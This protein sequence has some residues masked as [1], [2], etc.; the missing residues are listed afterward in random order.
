[1]LALRGVP[2][3][4]SKGLL[5]QFRA[6]LVDTGLS[7]ATVVNY[8]AD[9]RAFWRWSEKARDAEVS[10]FGLEPPD[11]EEY[12]AFLRDGR[13]QA[14]ATVNRRLQA[15]RKFFKFAMEQGW[16]RTNPAEDVALLSEAVSQRSRFLTPSDVARLLDAVRNGRRRWADRDWAIMQAFLGAGLKLSELTQLLLKDVHLD[17]EQPCLDVRNTAGEPD[18]CVPLDSQVCDAMR[19]YAAVRRSVR[20]VQHFFVNRDGRPLSTR[21]VQRLLRH[22]ARTAQLSDLT[23]QALRYLYARKAFEKSQD[24]ETVAR[25]L[26]HRHLATTVRYLRPSPTQRAGE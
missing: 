24:P 5:T 19:A 26:G 10:P 22:Y 21:S 1:L 4:D 12:C 13:N 17:L 15:L 2:T 8:M 16:T 14:P 7:P 25:L 20:G 11:I 3:I 6:H 18:R 23:T 9:L